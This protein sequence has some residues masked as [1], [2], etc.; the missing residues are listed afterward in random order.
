MILAILLGRL[1]T[2]AQRISINFLTATLYSDVSLFLSSLLVRFHCILYFSAL[3]WHNTPLV[4]T[5]SCMLHIDIE[6]SCPNRNAEL[7]V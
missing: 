3:S 1:I 5:S 2:L 7:D 6:K 4:L